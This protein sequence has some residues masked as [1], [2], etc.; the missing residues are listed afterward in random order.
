[1]ET[2][3][4]ER[5]H[6]EICKPMWI[7]E[8]WQS[9]M[10]KRYG[11]VATAALA[12]DRLVGPLVQW[13]GLQS[14]NRRAPSGVGLHGPKIKAF[15]NATCWSRGLTSARLADCLRRAESHHIRELVSKPRM[16]RNRHRLR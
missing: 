3:S 6:N 4:G 12:L 1:M 5:F 16:G 8:V 10:K 11:F 2:M 14:V 15:R 9:L 7:V 13:V